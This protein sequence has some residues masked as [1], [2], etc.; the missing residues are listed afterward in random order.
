MGNKNNSLSYFFTSNNK[1]AFYK[2][3]PTAIS[4]EMNN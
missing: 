3:F 4:N 1:R 2:N